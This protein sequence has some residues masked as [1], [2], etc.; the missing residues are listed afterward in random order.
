VYVLLSPADSIDPSTRVAPE[1]TPATDGKRSRSDKG[2]EKGEDEEN[3][4]D[5]VDAESEFVKEKQPRPA[6]GEEADEGDDI[7]DI[8]E[9]R[10]FLAKVSCRHASIHWVEMAE[11]DVSTQDAAAIQAVDMSRFMPAV[12]QAQYYAQSTYAAHQHQYNLKQHQQYFFQLQQRQHQQ[13]AAQQAAW[14]AQYNQ[15]HA[16]PSP[17]GVQHSVASPTPVTA[18]EAAAQ[19]SKNYEPNSAVHQ[20]WAYHQQMYQ[21]QMA[22]FQQAGGIIPSANPPPVAPEQSVDYSQQAQGETD[23]MEPA[24]VHGNGNDGE[25]EGSNKRARYE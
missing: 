19:Q 15:H 20:Q 9:S 22:Q 18:G 14:Q 17:G 6:T 4:P 16:M 1:S 25:N 2:G 12:D 21:N 8:A 7:N 5:S 3:N 10:T 11:F 13:Y 23:D 24:P